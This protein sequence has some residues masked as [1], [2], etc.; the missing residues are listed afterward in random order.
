MLSYNCSDTNEESCF[1]KK[2]RLV[3]KDGC[4]PLCPTLRCQ[5]GTPLYSPQFTAMPLPREIAGWGPIRSLLALSP[6]LLF[7][8]WLVVRRH[9][10]DG[11]SHTVSHLLP[12]YFFFPSTLAFPV[13]ITEL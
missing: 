13:P 8:P 4:I 10:F 2:N 5:H 12:A 7:V 3:L 6:L 11:K 1:G 9:Y